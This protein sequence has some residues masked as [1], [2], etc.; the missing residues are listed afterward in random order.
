MNLDGTELSNEQITSLRHLYRGLPRAPV[1]DGLLD[2]IRDARIRKSKRSKRLRVTLLACAASAMLG[3]AIVLQLSLDTSPERIPG[4]TRMLSSVHQPE[5]VNFL[6][7]AKEAHD[8]VTFSLLLPPEW[9]LQGYQGQQTLSWPGKLKAG[10]NLLSIPVVAL[11]PK[12]G[13]LIMQ[14]RDKDT[15]KEYKLHVDVKRGNA[16][17]NSI[18]NSD[19]T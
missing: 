9:E 6:V 16:Y 13:T 5:Q 18:N 2:R 17:F 7:T 15:V 1:P 8:E 12:P 11:Q 3:L 4:G 14:I 10:N 19:V